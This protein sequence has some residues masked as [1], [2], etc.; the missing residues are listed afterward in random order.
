M[1]MS[2][3]CYIL[4]WCVHKCICMRTYAG[5]QFHMCKNGSNTEQR[6]LQPQISWAAST[7]A[8]A[9]TSVVLGELVWNVE[10]Q[11]EFVIPKDWHRLQVDPSCC[12]WECWI[13]LLVWC[14]RRVHPTLLDHIE[15]RWRRGSSTEF[16]KIL[17]IYA[18]S[19]WSH[20][21]QRY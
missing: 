15:P 2:M 9:L 10:Q 21:C 16:V 14:P 12:S 13:Q 18:V 4:E 5:V 19:W 6:F 20:C 3:S 7:A 17:C 1:C 11:L 8:T